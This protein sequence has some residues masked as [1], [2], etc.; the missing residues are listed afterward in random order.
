MSTLEASLSDLVTR[1]LVTYEE[2]L[3]R[4]LY[5]KELAKPRPAVPTVTASG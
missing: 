5:P 3:S 4:S 1:G 2:A